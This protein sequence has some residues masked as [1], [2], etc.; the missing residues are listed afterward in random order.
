MHWDGL[1]GEASERCSTQTTRKMAPEGGFDD[2]IPD[3][4]KEK[5]VKTR[6]YGVNTQ[7]LKMEY[8]LVFD[9]NRVQVGISFQR[10]IFFQLDLQYF[11][12]DCWR[13]ND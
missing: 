10:C 13:R 12:R 4:Q 9:C 5:L 7:I 11:G 3:R 1:N 8:H 2:V 6:S